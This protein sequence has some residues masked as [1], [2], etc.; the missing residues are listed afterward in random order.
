MTTSRR[1]CL[2]LALA[3]LVVNL[4][5]C[6]SA[7]QNTIDVYEFKEKAKV[8]LRETSRKAE[9]ALAQ[10]AK[11]ALDDLKAYA[12]YD[13]CRNEEQ[14]SPIYCER[15]L[16]QTLFELCMDKFHDYPHCNSTYR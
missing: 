8:T 12:E 9:E 11:D 6:G 7:K 16:G 3:P 14:N 1:L 4:V 2:M 5:A 15:K 13:T 10:A